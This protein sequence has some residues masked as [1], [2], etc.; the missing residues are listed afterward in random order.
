[1]FKVLATQDNFT[2]TLNSNE[3]LDIFGKNIN[4]TLMEVPGL[5]K[6]IIKDEVVGTFEVSPY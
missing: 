3:M 2:S 4:P 1:M 5:K 6:I